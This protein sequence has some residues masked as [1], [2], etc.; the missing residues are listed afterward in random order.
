M[1]I[2]LALAFLATAAPAAPERKCVQI[3][4]DAVPAAKTPYRFGRTH[5]LMLQN[6]LGHF[7]RIQQRVI[8]IERYEKGQLERCAASFYLGTYFDNA[9]P[10]DFVADFAASSKTVVWAGYNI[11]KLPPAEV[12]RLWSA[13]YRRQ[14]VL[15]P[16]DKDADGRPAFYRLYDYKGQV[17]E[18]YGAYDPADA[19]R[20]HAAFEISLL[21]L[22]EPAA[23]RFVAAW[24]R[25]SGKIP[26][27]TPYAL[28]N[29]RHWYIADSPF[30]FITEEDRYLIFAD[31]LFDI[32]DEP[33]LRGP[34]EKKPA[35]FRV[36]DVHPGIPAWQIY[37]MVDMLSL[38]GAP[39][40]VSVI[41]MWVDAL[42]SMKLPIRW[43]TAADDPAFSDF[44]AYAA[45][46]GASFVLHGLTHQRGF[47]RNPF[48]G[49]SGDD[50]EF[51]DR[52]KNRPVA[53]ETDKDI[54]GR[55]ADARALLE[56]AGA[57]AS[58]WLAPHY[59]ASPRAY[60]V[61]ARAYEWNVGRAIYFPEK[62]GREPPEGA[63]PAGQFFPYEIY[64]DHY[65][66]RMIPENV[67]NVQP[68]L[69]DQVLKPVTVDDMIRI[70]R[71]NSVL[72]DAWA[73]FFVHPSMLELTAM[74]GDAAG[75][76][77]VR[78]LLAAAAEHGYEFVALSKWTKEN[79]KPIRPEPVETPP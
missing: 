53:G 51:W 75:S 13:R 59:Q 21:D 49:A 4:Y 79:L 60:R 68:Y 10:P 63:Q 62:A 24:A 32:L 70:M 72:R 5:A 36:E 64:G 69:N 22:L 30:S 42:G 35:L 31:L 2:L 23:E 17:F 73:S 1:Q 77:E 14:S 44:L 39:F 67:G 54:E 26:G 25:H 3:Y 29:G 20:F 8:P 7:P 71:R 9:V 61:F 27:R 76:K 74:G 15:E 45:A 55:L 16:E 28:V 50:F 38:A 6:L 66:Q 19:G 47:A 40:S 33:P 41:P 37:G 48:T 34:G 18:K 12:A 78:R 52:V 46:R 56:A 58:A 57:K 65:G 11:W 43:R